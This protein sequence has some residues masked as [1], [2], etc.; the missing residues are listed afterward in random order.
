MIVAMVFIGIMW[1]RVLRWFVPVF[2]N[3]R[4]DLRNIIIMPV[5]SVIV[6]VDM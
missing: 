1:V 5:V 6:D 3:V 2:V 4:P